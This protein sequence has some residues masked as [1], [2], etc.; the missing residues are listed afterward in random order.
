MG[1]NIKRAEEVVLR[2]IFPE[3]LPAY[4]I[5]KMRPLPHVLPAQEWDV[6]EIDTHCSSSSLHTESRGFTMISRD[7][8]RKQLPC[9]TRGTKSDGH[10]Q[11]KYINIR[12]H[13]GIL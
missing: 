1:E 10:G 13:G 9:E 5:V 7:I 2:R 11:G 6:G 8:Y 12:P 4:F 3:T